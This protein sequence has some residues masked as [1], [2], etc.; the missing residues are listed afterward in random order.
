MRDPARIEPILELIRKVWSAS[1]DLRLSQLLVTV[2]R[3]TE[4]C[5]QVFYFED[6]EL[7]KRLQHAVAAITTPSTDSNN[8][9]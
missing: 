7:L 3:P 4:P 9:P 1:P 6:T 8:G 2:I 5:P